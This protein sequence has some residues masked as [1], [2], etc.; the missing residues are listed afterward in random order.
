MAFELGQQVSKD[1]FILQRHPFFNLT[2]IL[3][4]FN[5]FQ[6]S[7]LHTNVVCIESLLTQ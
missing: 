5:P 2:R 1:K 6:C 4:K 7:A 3:P